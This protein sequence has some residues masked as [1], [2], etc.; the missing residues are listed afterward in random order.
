MNILKG[1]F[2]GTMAWIILACVM[3]SII[4]GITAEKFLLICVSI[5]GGLWCYCVKDEEL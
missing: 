1:I 2:Y 3:S 4:S 5:A